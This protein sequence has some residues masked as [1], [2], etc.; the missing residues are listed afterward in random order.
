MVKSLI[1]KLEFDALDLDEDFGVN[2]CSN[3]ASGY[4]YSS[5]ALKFLRENEINKVL[6]DMKDDVL[7][8]LIKK[9]CRNIFIGKPLSTLSLSSNHAEV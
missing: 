1:N 4:L 6:T 7:V 8:N 5:D 3:V 9:T 2:L